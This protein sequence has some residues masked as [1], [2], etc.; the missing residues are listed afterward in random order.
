M[1]LT[2]APTERL[3]QLMRQDRVKLQHKKAVFSSHKPGTPYYT[4][5]AREI[6][7]LIERIRQMERIID[8]RRTGENQ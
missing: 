2:K 3:L 7:A 1:N 6:A 8:S 5:A 4:R